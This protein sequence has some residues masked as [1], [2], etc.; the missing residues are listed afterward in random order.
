MTK[1]TC[2]RF[3]SYGNFLGEDCAAGKTT[4]DR[5]K[6]YSFRP[7]FRAQKLCNDLGMHIPGLRSERS[8]DLGRWVRKP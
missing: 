7:A 3:C 1:D 6:S 2:N 5:L 8:I 4:T